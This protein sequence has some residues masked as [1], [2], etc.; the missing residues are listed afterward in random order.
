MFARRIGDG[1][2][3]PVPG[4]GG[5]RLDPLLFLVKAVAGDDQ[6]LQGCGGGH[7]GIAERGRIEPG[8][9]ADLVLFDPATVLPR[10]LNGLP[11]RFAVGTGPVF[12]NAVVIDIDASSGRAASIERLS[13]IIEV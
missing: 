2:F 1:F 3:D 9:F 7:F 6:A 5:L 11:T 4:V 12:F 10:F 13:R 8:A